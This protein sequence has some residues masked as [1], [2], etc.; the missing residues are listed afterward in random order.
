MDS[1]G[2]DVFAQQMVYGVI[3]IVAVTLTIDRSKIA[4]VK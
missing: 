1:A 4:M 3:V 2:V